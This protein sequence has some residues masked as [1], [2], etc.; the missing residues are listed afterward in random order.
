MEWWQRCL[1]ESYVQK[2]NIRDIC[3]D[4]ERRVKV[5]SHGL[6]WDS[7]PHE[8]VDGTVCDIVV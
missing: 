5:R 8:V 2:G 4:L 3:L 7:Y 1:F 6:G